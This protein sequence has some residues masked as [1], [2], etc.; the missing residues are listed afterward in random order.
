MV[1]IAVVGADDAEN[2][3]KER[4]ALARERAQLEARRSADAQERAAEARRE[5]AKLLTRKPR[6]PANVR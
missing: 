3:T 2:R 1:T 5:A 4:I 6:Q